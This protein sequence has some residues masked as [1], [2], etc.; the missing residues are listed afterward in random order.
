[1]KILLQLCGQGVRRKRCRGEPLLAISGTS[2]VD[3]RERLARK[4]RVEKSFNNLVAISNAI[5]FSP[6]SF[7]SLR[8][9]QKL[10]MSGARAASRYFE[11]A[12]RLGLGLEPSVQTAAAQAF[13][14]LRDPGRA[15]RIIKYS[16]EHQ[17]VP[18][19]G[20]FAAAMTGAKESGDE[21]LEK[22]VLLA[23]KQGERVRA[24]GIDVSTSPVTTCCCQLL[25]C[26]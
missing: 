25:C 11:T 20:V 22:E 7:P 3:A 26:F 9:S 23:M 17:V 12:I 10:M 6:P 16:M 21:E 5:T 24:L 8:S 2:E 4:V 15:K 1:M 19:P 18:P 13:R 14:A